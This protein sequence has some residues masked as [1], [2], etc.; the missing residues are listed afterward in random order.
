MTLSALESPSRYFRSTV[1]RGIPED[2]VITDGGDFG[3]GLIKRV[4]VIT[5]GEALGHG[6]WIDE[7][8][9]ASV[10]DA[11]NES[12]N[13]GVKARF[14][15]PDGTGDALGTSLGRVKDA[16]VEGDQVLADLHLSEA[17]HKSPDGN[18]A[19]YVMTLAV[20]TPDQFGQSISF[21]R[22]VD[23][24]DALLLN[25]GAEF[26]GDDLHLAKFESPDPDNVKNLRHARLHQLH[27]VD[28]VDQ[29]AANP[30]GLF[31]RGRRGVASEAEQFLDYA[32][33]LSETVPALTAFSMDPDRVRGFVARY[34]QRRGIDIRTDEDPPTPTPEDAM[35]ET[36]TPDAPG[37]E[38]AQSRADFV[39]DLNRYTE[40]FGAENGAEW[41]AAG[42][43]WEEALELQLGVLQAELDEAH[44]QLTA[45]T[46]R[47]AELQET[48]AAERAGEDAIDL[49]PPAATP[50][51]DAK[52]PG[53][54]GIKVAGTPEDN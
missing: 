7:T 9:L 23:A 24:E 49:G 20:E 14:T 47:V 22:D 36:N 27:A 33:G 16:R 45:Q 51:P 39:A 42:K 10:A 18:L 25:H 31:H 48:L 26:D 54:L 41:F 53:R 5:R 52:E 8:F 17:A 30:Q 1:A 44:N 32:L 2:A 38:D 19:V 11:I 21:L 35:S 46:A 40:R 43:S 50:D 12:G 3:A 6:M 4:A 37:T 15:H 34:T 28:S 13:R 29:P